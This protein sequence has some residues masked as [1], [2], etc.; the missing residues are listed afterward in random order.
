MLVAYADSIKAVSI[1]NNEIVYE[2]N[3]N[4]AFG[5]LV[6]LVKDPVTG[7]V[8]HFHTFFKCCLQCVC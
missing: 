4:E 5:K 7:N 1:L 6:N 3:Y 2:D 8:H